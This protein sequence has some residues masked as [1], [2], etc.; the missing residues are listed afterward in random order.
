M[1]Q[2]AAGADQSPSHK[3]SD[4]QLKCILDVIGLSWA[5]LTKETYGAGL[6]VFHV[7]CDTHNITEENH[8]PVTHSLLLNFLCS[9]AGSYSG[10]TLANYAAGLKAWHLLHRRSWLIPP[11]ELKAVLDSTTAS[12]PITSNHPKRLP[13]TPSI[14]C[15]IQNHLNLDS[16]LDAAVFACLT[17]TFYA[18]ARLGKFTVSAIKEFD[19]TKHITRASVSTTTDHNGLPVTKFHLPRTKCSP[20]EGED[21][22]WA[23]Q[24][25]PSD[26]RTALDNHLTVNQAGGNAHLFAWKHA[27]GLRPLSKKEVVK[28]SASIAIT[29]NL[30]ELKGHGLRIGGTLKYL[31]H[32]IPFEVIKTMGRW[33]SETF[34]RY[35]RDQATILAPY[36]QA[37]PI[38]E[39]FT[40]YTIP[41]VR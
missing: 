35:L 23:A 41:P 19:P 31:L 9:C 38:L 27:R 8:C 39:P 17:T 4:T 28:R 26:P 12:A 32:G 33:S 29:A 21:A 11:S 25:G 30:L 6:L 24:E 2:T 1:R 22:Y 7:F 14:L 10:S 34:T 37:S 20:I 13:F 5:Q 36:I 40:H 3:V 16:P 15:S 18:I